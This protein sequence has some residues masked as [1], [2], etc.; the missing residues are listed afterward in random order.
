[1]RPELR[2]RPTCA[3]SECLGRCQDCRQGGQTEGE[4]KLDGHEGTS[5]TAPV[6]RLNDSGYDIAAAEPDAWRHYDRDAPDPG[7]FQFDWLSARHPD[8]YHRFA[9]TSD[10]LVSELEHLVDLRGLDVIDVGAG[11]GRSAIGLARTA[12]S[13]LAVDAYASVIDFGE[14]AVR[15]AGLTNVRYR[16]GDRSQLPAADGSVDAVVCCWAELDQVEAV[17]VLKPGGLLVHMGGHPTGPDELTPILS[18]DFPEL[19]LANRQDSLRDPH[20]GAVDITLPASDWPDVPM[21]EDA[22]HAHD[23][24]YTADYGTVEEAAAI[25]GRLFGPKAA[26]YLLDRKQAT[27]W[28][29]LRIWYARVEK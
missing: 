25:F 7:Y 18:E 23:F 9:L 16:R 20:R 27:V 15:E 6:A 4:A 12:T 5:E 3:V 26:K 10:A 14:R 22:L 8:L 24:T 13:V 1:M 29:R 2:P 19:V 11:T 21:G 17:R 28:S